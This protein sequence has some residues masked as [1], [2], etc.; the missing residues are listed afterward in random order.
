LPTTNASA[1]CTVGGYSSYAVNVTNVA[2]IQLAVN[3][4]R[5]A[6]LR[7]V[8]KNTG[9]DFNGKS[10]GAGALGIWTHHL[11]EIDYIANYQS[12]SYSGPAV[13]MGA[14]VQAHEIYEKANEL[15]FTVVGG[16][17]KVRYSL[18]MSFMSNQLIRS[19]RLLVSLVVTFSAVVT[20]LCPVSMVLPLIRSS[21]WRLSFPTVASS[22][23]LSKATLISSGP[24]VVAVV[25][26]FILPE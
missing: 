15:G 2:Q 8:V 12:S 14:G 23:L 21:P 4:A 18:S 7:L 17:G 24:S 3:F 16:E 13:K 25:V 5:N 1:S 19:Y 26:S 11:K 22:L 10:T 6:G 20:L 9:H